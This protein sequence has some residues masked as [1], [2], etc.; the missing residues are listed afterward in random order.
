M[1]WNTLP[2]W[3]RGAMLYL[4]GCAFISLLFGVEWA[5]DWWERFDEFDIGEWHDPVDEHAEK[6]NPL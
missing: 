2:L 5:L 6:P 1:D 4:F 3:V